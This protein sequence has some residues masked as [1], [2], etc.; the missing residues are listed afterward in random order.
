[1]KKW[2]MSC[3]ALLL[4][5]ALVACAPNMKDTFNNN[6]RSFI[7]SCEREVLIPETIERI[8]VTGSMAQIVTFAL[9]PDL[10]VGI[11]SEWDSAA[12]PFIPEEYRQLPVLGQLYGGKGELNPE[13][14]LQSGAQIVIDIG[15]DKSG[16]AE[17]MDRLQQQTGIPFVH[18]DSSL[19]RLDETYRL[20]GELLDRREA[21]QVLSDYCRSTYA[22]AQEL[23]SRIERKECL[24]LLGENGLHVIGKDTY[25]SGVID[26][27]AENIAVLDNPTSKGTGNEV[28]ME[29][30]MLWNPEYIIFAPDSIGESVAD[31]PLWQNLQAIRSGNYAVAP[32]GPYNWISMPPSAQQL[33][34]LIWM[35]A[36]LYPE[37]CGYD[38][39][40]EVT[41]YFALFYH[42][43]LTKDQL[44]ALIG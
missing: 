36:I 26:L 39:G 20:L 28:D 38:L 3:I 33:L 15:D 13:S 30:L 24:Y 16:V 42:T 4:V 14:L 40:E 37:A 17:D 32:I 25:H 5:A 2:L 31:D 10:L 29:Q 9:A 27:M 23:S 43:D 41:Q 11:S 21:A 6:S 12:I 18:I 1:M 8:A 19:S 44:S 34:G 35:G 22:R 7:D